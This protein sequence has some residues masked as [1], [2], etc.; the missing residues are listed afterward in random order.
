MRYRTGPSRKHVAYATPAR[1]P[2][3]S[4]LWYRSIMEGGAIESRAIESGAIESRQ[5]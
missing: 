5:A 3:A 1:T 4:A 2:E